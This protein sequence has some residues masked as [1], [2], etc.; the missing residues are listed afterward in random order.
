MP[1]A[2][3]AS[4]ESKALTLLK[5]AGE[6]PSNSFPAL[7]SAATR[8][9]SIV[10]TSA[11]FSSNRQDWT[12]FGQY[13]QNATAA[14]LQACGGQDAP[15]MPSVQNSMEQMLEI[16]EKI[17][18]DVD[19]LQRSHPPGRIR[20][21]S[22]DRR[23]IADMKTQVDVALKPMYSDRRSQIPRKPDWDDPKQILER[24]LKMHRNAVVAGHSV[25]SGAVTPSVHVLSPSERIGDRSL[26]PVV[27]N[28]GPISDEQALVDYSMPASE[29]THN[30][31]S[32]RA[33]VFNISAISGGTIMCVD[34]DQTVYYGL[35]EKQLAIMRTLERL[36]S[37]N[38]AS[39]DLLE[40]GRP[41]SSSSSPRA[42]S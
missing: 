13:I 9:F 8:V 2:S 3:R 32:M 30:R 38:S 36:T 41:E 27:R 24:I 19:E 20:L 6:I 15:D 5:I 1:Q 22:K 23:S 18:R 26:V 11:K 12:N 25:A 42:R 14:V 31:V 4:V 16:L 21:A 17:N 28:A 39:W 35:D 7:K 40:Y 34:G 10:E 37:S 29:L 33:S